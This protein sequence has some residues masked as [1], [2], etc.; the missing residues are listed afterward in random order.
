[1]QPI[2]IKSLLSL[3]FFLVHVTASVN[4]TDC[5]A[6]F[7]NDS[8][9]TLVGGTDWQGNPVNHTAA[10]ALTYDAC[11]SYCGTGAEAFDWS[12]FSQQ[13]SAWLLPWLALVSQLPFGAETRLDNFISGRFPRDAHRFVVLISFLSPQSRPHS[14]F[15][16]PC[17]VLPRYHRSQHPLGKRPFL[18][19]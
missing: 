13:F 8:D 16:L 17:C 12:I 9:A 4:F 15:S 1:M 6:K 5:L 18:G 3:S 14:R 19:D 2:F 10:D 7:K 11:T